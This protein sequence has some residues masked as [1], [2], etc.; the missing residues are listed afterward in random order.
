M[1]LFRSG[2]LFTV[3]LFGMGFL[4][5]AQDA[6][7]KKWSL[8]DCLEYGIENHPQIKIAESSV[9]SQKARLKQT[10]AYWDP[11]L[12][13]RASWN[14]R[15][16]DSGGSADDVI[17]STSESLGVSKVLYDSGRNRYEEISARSLIKSA[18]AGRKNTLIEIA[19]TI[20]KA[21]FVAQQAQALVSVREDTLQGYQ[22]HLEKVETYVEVG[23]RP[24]YDI[25]R[26]RVDV[27]NAQ[28]ELISAKSRLKVAKANLARA[29]GLEEELDIADFALTDLPELNAS[30]DALKEEAFARPEIL[31]AR[32]NIDSAAARIDSARK[33]LKPYVAASAD[34][35]WSGTVTPLNRQWSAGVSLNWS[36]FDG[37]LTRSQIDSAKSQ[38]VSARENF[39]NVKLAVNAELENA[40]T[41]LEDALE[42]YGATE[43]LVQQASESMNLAEGRYDAGLGNPIE[44]N[45]ARVEYAKA[46][47]NFVVAYF[48][49]LIAMSELER[50]VG[51]LPA[52]YRIKEIEPL[53][54]ENRK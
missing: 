48:D 10:R 28:V 53:P 23:T 49:S 40:I 13:L 38:L 12:D 43:V 24:P 45:D 51:K 22:K 32:F 8:T 41:G 50:V 25:T 17:D 54:E 31:S 26:A 9:Q 47:G 27:A 35:S 39:R 46:R 5:F 34:Y 7:V 21:F 1:K 44:I 11:K 52:E 18:E 33:S 29:I 4:A 30:K 36:L 3:F 2:S 16:I 15:K 20:K 42:R 37:A 14:H 6:G 19:S